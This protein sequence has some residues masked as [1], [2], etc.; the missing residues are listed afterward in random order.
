M[1][2]KYFEIKDGRKLSELTESEQRYITNEWERLCERYNINTSEHIFFQKTNGRFFRAERGRI[3]A[4]RYSGSAG[5]YWA[6]VYGN[7]KVWGFRKNPFGEYD[8][9]PTE[10]RFGSLTKENGE[11]VTIPKTVKT[12][13]EALELARKLGF[14]F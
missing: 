1:S 8:P 4:S 5:G 9:E 10:K 12:K 13:K 3:S 2:Y 14:E 7:C 11:I 6:I